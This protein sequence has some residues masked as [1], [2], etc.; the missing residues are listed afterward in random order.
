VPCRGSLTLSQY[1]LLRIAASEASFHPRQGDPV[2]IA[3]PF[4]QPPPNPAGILSEQKRGRKI[5]YMDFAFR[6]DH[7]VTLVEIA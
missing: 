4:E 3:K 2:L 7:N 5:Y 6:S 1:R